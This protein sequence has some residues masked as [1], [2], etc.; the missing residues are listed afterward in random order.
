MVGL[1]VVKRWGYGRNFGSLYIYVGG[2]GLS[3][4][5]YGGGCNIGERKIESGGVLGSGVC[6]YLFL[7]ISFR[8]VRMCGWFYCGW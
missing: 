2:F 7:G 4:G 8:S 6:E 5:W 1:V 3:L